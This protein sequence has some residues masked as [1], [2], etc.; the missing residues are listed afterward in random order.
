[1][2]KGKFKNWWHNVFS[3]W[4]KDKVSDNFRS[5]TRD[6]HEGLGRFLNGVDNLWNRVTGAGLTGAEREANKY[7][8]AQAEEQYAREVEFYEKYQSPKAQLAQGVNPF[9]SYSQGPTVSGGSP[10]SVSPGG[11]DLSI[12]ELVQSMFGMIQQKRLND[13]EISLN[14]SAEERNYSEANERNI[15]SET[16]RD[17]N[18]ATI[19]EKLSNIELN[20]SNIELITSKILNTNQDTALKS[21][22]LRKVA[23]EILNVE[24]D[25]KLKAEQLNVMLSQIA[26]LDADTSVKRQKVHNLLQEV[27]L[28]QKQLDVFT[29]QIALMSTQAGVNKQEQIKLQHEWKSIQQD[30]DHKEIMNALQEI[31]L[32]KES[33]VESGYDPENYSDKP[34]MRRIVNT[35]NLFDRLVDFSAS[36]SFVE[37]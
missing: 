11:S 37:K 12:I 2:S 35:I 24:A 21:E 31:L 22:Q 20:N 30:Y 5:E 32:R 13:S 3:P 16:L 18:L 19:M 6:D 10:Q 34:I 15:N 4:W 7:S 8:A 25:T 27:I 14:K 23:F 26:N 9:G 1:M 17:M 29:A 36:K 28:S 33:N